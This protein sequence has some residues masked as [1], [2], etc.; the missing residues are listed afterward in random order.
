MSLITDL[1]KVNKR[2][3]FFY[4]AVLLGLIITPS[5]FLF[6]V[7][8]GVFKEMDFAKLI[9]VSIAISAP[10]TIS[11]FP[12]VYRMAS[13]LLDNVKENKEHETSI[14]AATLALIET[15]LIFYSINIER[16]FSGK[17][18]SSD[19][20][21]SMCRIAYVGLIGMNIVISLID[22]L[23]ARSERKKLNKKRPLTEEPN[24]NII[25]TPPTS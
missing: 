18:L 6:Q 9:I 7:F 25:P 21:I 12:F 8:P 16:Y 15:C 5:W 4:F 19:E 24:V 17:P 22:Y 1:E 13:K 23:N 10:V 3:G 2:K 14:L 11:I 20:A